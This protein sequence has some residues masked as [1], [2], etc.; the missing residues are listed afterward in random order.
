MNDDG[1]FLIP[2]SSSG[3]DAS[4][5]SKSNQEGDSNPENRSFFYKV[6]GEEGRAVRKDIWAPS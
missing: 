5:L 1:T 2:S 6:V 3:P 4:K